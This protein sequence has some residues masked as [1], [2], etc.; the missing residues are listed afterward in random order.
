MSMARAS[1]KFVRNADRVRLVLT[2]DEVIVAEGANVT[3]IVREIVSRG[4]T[5]LFLS[6]SYAMH[7]PTNLD[8]LAEAT[9][10]RLEEPLAA[11]ILISECAW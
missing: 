8:T 1:V 11:F 5:K 9:Q 10:M 4:L 6:D 7:L 3:L 2:I